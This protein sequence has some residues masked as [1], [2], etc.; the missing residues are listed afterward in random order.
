MILTRLLIS[1]ILLSFISSNIY[2]QRVQ[3]G[4][5]YSVKERDALTVIKE[6]VKK[7]NWKNTLSHMSV[8]K[9]INRLKYDM[10]RT[11]KHKHFHYIPYY[12]LE[13][14]ITDK[15]GNTIYPK[16]FRY[17]PLDYFFMPGRIIII[18]D[19]DGDIRW[20]KKI[21]KR[22]DR[23]IT[24]GNRFEELQNK[25]HIT[26]FKFMKNMPERLGVES[27]P[28]IIKQERNYF[29]VNEIVVKG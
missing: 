2:A 5:T 22:T 4:T 23:I 8:A 29:V 11:K 1:C 16:G 9:A 19:K 24:T 14:D 12:T 3:I 18:G 21:R 7:V 25:Y 10:P 17:N 13:Q 15:N 27:V 26:A 28:C 20:L 6:K